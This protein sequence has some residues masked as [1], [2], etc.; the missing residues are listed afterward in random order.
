MALEWIKRYLSNH[1]QYVCYN[2][3]NSE[4]KEIKCGVPHRSILGPLLFILYINDMY[5]V[6][7]LHHIILFA[8]DTNFNFFYWASNIDDITNVV[9]KELKQLD[10]TIFNKICHPS[11]RP[12]WQVDK[13]A[14]GL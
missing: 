9:N 4:F 10:L 12:R 2:N 5:D 8:D 3:S 6:S 13:E 14:I 7:K 1:R 11:Q